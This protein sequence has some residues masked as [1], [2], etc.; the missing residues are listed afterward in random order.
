MKHTLAAL[1]ENHPGVLNRVASLFRRRGFNIESLAVGTTEQEGI[2]RMTFVV[3][4]DDNVG[5]QVEKQLYKLIDIIK[6]SDLSREESIV[7]EIALIKVRSEKNNRRDILDLV[8]IFR[9][10]A[11]D[12]TEY[13]VVIQLVAHPETVDSLLE[14]LAAYPIIEMVRTGRIAMLRGPQAISVPTTEPV[15]VARFHQASG[16]RPEGELPYV[17]E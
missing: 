9:A 1:V 6:V 16:R 11:V 15:E 13:S 2:S 5:E 3:E 8:E 7:R 4:G 12:I 14:N 10:Q 17:S